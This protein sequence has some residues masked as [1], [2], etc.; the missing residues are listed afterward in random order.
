MRDQFKDGSGY[1]TSARL[2]ASVGD[3]AMVLSG[4]FNLDGQYTFTHGSIGGSDRGIEVE[5][6][7]EAHDSGSGAKFQGRFADTAVNITATVPGDGSGSVVGTLGG[8]PV[9]LRLRQTNGSGAFPPARLTGIYS[10]SPEILALIV[11]AVAY[12]GP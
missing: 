11:G 10:G 9:E 5:I 2:T 3:D 1:E 8:K 7:I 6:A 12:F 4:T